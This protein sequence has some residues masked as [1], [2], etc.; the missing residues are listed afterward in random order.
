MFLLGFPT[1]IVL[2]F[3][4][5]ALQGREN[6]VRAR[7]TS[8]TSSTVFELY[9][10]QASLSPGDFGSWIAPKF[11]DIGR[12]SSDIADNSE[13]EPKERDAKDGLD[14]NFLMSKLWVSAILRDIVTTFGFVLNKP[15]NLLPAEL[16][17]FLYVFCNYIRLRWIQ[18]ADILLE[19]WQNVSRLNPTNVKPVS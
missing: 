1:P 10:I 12:S 6:V 8:T 7:Y 5:H 14:L 17:S 13:G 9:G 18:T 2:T 15:D 19:D 3:G 11:G 4:G 16:Y